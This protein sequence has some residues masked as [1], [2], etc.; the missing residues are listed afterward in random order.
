MA[1][2]SAKSRVVPL[3]GYPASLRRWFGWL[4]WITFA[5]LV[6]LPVVVAGAVIALHIWG[7][8]DT[9]DKM[10]IA[11]S[12]EVLL[13]MVVGLVAIFWGLLLTWFGVESAFT[14]EASGE[15][16]NTKGKGTIQA[17]APG[18]VLFVGGMALVGFCL[19]K[20]LQ[21]S[22]SAPE[23]KRVPVAD[24]PSTEYDEFPSRR[25][26]P[27]LPAVNPELKPDSR[28]TK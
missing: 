22:Q 2:E 16:G 15:V 3:A 20:P 21:F 17:S 19:Y 4:F 10:A 1:D 13:G 27:K 5:I 23:L 9:I 7:K 12:L 24:K 11:A 8:W 14:L 6:V 25:D 28:G 18:L 26:L